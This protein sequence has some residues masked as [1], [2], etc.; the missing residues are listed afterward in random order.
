MAYRSYNVAHAPPE[1]RGAFLQKVAFWTFAGLLLTAVVAIASTLFVVPLVAKLGTIG[2]LVAVYGSFFLSQSVARN[3]VYGESKMAGFVLGNASQGVAFGFLLAIVAFSG[4]FGDGLRLV[5]SCLFITLASAGGMLAYV[6]TFRSN[7]SMLGSALSMIALPM[8]A[9]VVLQL[10]FPIGGSFGLLL[11]GLF[12]L[13]SAG[14]LLYKLNSIV[15]D[16]DSERTVEGGYELSLSIVVLL[17]NLISL[18]N[19][20]RRG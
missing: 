17:W 5:A 20:A 12:V 18:M 7:F 10:V 2:I 19:R 16:F 6:T 8:L 15:H 13:V 14:S 3:M 9:L 1:I 11:S 4:P